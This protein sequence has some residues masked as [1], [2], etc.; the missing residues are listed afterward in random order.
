VTAAP[1]RVLVIGDPYFTAADFERALPELADVA[2]VTF[3]QIETTVTPPPATDSERAL[4]EYAGVPSEIAAASMGFE[5]L[6]VHGA[7]VSAEVFEVGDVRLICCARGGP[8]NVDLNAA[9]A[10]GVPVCNTPGKNAEA[11]A[12]LT[13]AFALMLIRGVTPS[14]RELVAGLW[15]PDSAFD[16]R[17]FFGDEAPSLTLGLVGFGH[18]GRHVASR[19]SQLGFTVLAH[20][21]FTSVHKTGDVT[22]VGLDELL[23]RSDIV[24]LHAR[25]TADN[26]RMMGRPQFARMRAGAFFINTAR[27]QLVD[28][29]ALVSA[30]TSG[31][32]AGA[33]LDVIEPT[34]DG[35]RNPLLDLANVLVTP[36]IGGATHE[37]LARG[38]KMAGQAIRAYAAG[39]ALP[40]VVNPAATGTAMTRLPVAGGQ[41]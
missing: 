5:V 15:Q 12:E 26:Q 19:A 7:A 33:A 2:Q 18:V 25:V 34:S 21:P 6:V 14:S 36:H 13:V 11:V 38:A 24:S 29:P 27:E 17:R 9:T 31:A 30:L 40:F 3:R 32:L 41:A 37:T 39:D 8:V 10:A 1:V 23:E 16:G 35:Q 28:E 22:L 4:R 20:D